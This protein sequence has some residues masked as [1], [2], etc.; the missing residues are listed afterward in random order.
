MNFDVRKHPKHIPS[1][2]LCKAA[3]PPT[4]LEVHGENQSLSKCS[5]S[6]IH[7]HIKTTSARAYHSSALTPALNRKLRRTTT[8]DSSAAGPPLSINILII[9]CWAW[10]FP[11]VT[12]RVQIAEEH[13]EWTGELYEVIRLTRC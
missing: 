2:S 5:A 10:G 4:A 13:A 12:S 9:I 3:I 1:T 7:E 8:V 6:S 11:S